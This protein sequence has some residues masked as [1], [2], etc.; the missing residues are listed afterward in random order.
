MNYHVG[1]N[2]AVSDGKIN[3]NYKRYNEEIDE[4]SNE[5]YD[6]ITGNFG[7]PISYYNN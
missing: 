6:F 2:D 5:E 1:R 3:L 7:T 4:L